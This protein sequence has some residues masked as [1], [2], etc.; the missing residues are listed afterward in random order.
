VIVTVLVM[1]VVLKKIREL[2]YF[3]FLG[4]EMWGLT[5]ERE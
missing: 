3:C 4:D 1:V 2:V 5:L